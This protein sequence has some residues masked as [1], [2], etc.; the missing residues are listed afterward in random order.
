MN[1]IAS[2]RL[3]RPL[4]ILGLLTLATGLLRLSI[5]QSLTAK[6]KL[7][8][9]V[10]RRIGLLD[11]VAA[12]LDDHRDPL[13][14]QHSL[15]TLLK[16]RVY[17]PALGYEDLNDHHSL[18]HDTLLQTALGRHQALASSPT[19]CRMENRGHHR[20]ALLPFI[21]PLSII[22]SRPLRPRPKN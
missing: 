2:K 8:R 20:Q 9:D 4:L 13:R 18:R 17:G 21:R 10:D 1:S 16:Q 14:I 19:M 11:D 15:A 12:R 22:S 5:P 3:S 6:L 7:L